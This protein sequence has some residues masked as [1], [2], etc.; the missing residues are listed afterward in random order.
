MVNGRRAGETAGID[1]THERFAKETL[2]FAGDLT[3]A[4]ISHSM[5]INQA[6]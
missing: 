2:V 6:E 3:Y 4:S 5:I 1:V